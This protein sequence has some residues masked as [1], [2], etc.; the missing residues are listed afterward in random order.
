M[1]PSSVSL[2][3]PGGPSALVAALSW[4]QDALLGT[5]ATTVAVIAVAWI[6]LLMLS[7]RISGRHGVRVLLGCFVLFGASTIAAGIQ[8]GIAATVEAGQPLAQDSINAASAPVLPEPP[9]TNAD[10]YAG[11]SVPTR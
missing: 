3:D 4:V 8:T 9:P 10:P 5:L 7:G 2:A 11:A 1:T 6:G